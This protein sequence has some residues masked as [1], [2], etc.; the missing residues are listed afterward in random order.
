MDTLD[1][2]HLLGVSFRTAP[3][4]VR[5]ALALD[6]R[7]VEEVLARAGAHLGAGEALVL[8][9]CN[10]TELYVVGASEAAA[11]TWHQAVLATTGA[12]EAC[13]ALAAARYHR[14]GRAA[15]RHL[16][17]V[18]S[19][20]ESA[21]L[22]DN[23]IVGQLRAAVR[24]AEASGT[25]G[26]RLRLVADH[27]LRTSKRA[28]TDTAIGAGGAGIG[29]AVATLVAERGPTARRV[30]LV[31]AGDAA[32]VIAREL[33]KR[34]PVE[35]SIV[36]RTVDRAAA[37]AAQHGAA[38][39]PLVD[40]PAAIAAADVVVAATGSSTAVLTPEVVDAARRLSPACAPLVIDAGVPR[41]VD[42]ACAADVEVVAMDSLADR[43]QR[44]A[45]H[46]AAAVPDVER[47][48]EAGLA[49]WRAAEVRRLIRQGL[50]HLDHP[51]TV[52]AAS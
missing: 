25:L 31:G 33:T 29:S 23:E 17:R 28:R 4:A 13:P 3:L 11:A 19:G 15:A 38:V 48:I 6:G 2:L 34:L 10:R 27:A 36:N 14:Q 16:F 35:L 52:P 20:L 46:R 26:P 9:T 30:V 43:T 37:L 40:L 7:Q 44:V 50:G 39:R 45:Q 42:P 47:C 8:S 49:R 1:R 32:A 41:N 5:E 51:S 12:D 24:T 18:A 22:G 21:L